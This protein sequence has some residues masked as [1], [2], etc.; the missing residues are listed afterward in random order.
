MKHKT[1]LEKK[2][3][4]M[5]HAVKPFEPHTDHPLVQQIK[6]GSYSRCSAAIA[7]YLNRFSKRA[8]HPADFGYLFNCQNNVLAFG[9]YRRFDGQLYG[10]VIPLSADA[11]IIAGFSQ[12]LLGKL[13]LLG[14]YVRF[15][16]LKSY[17]A[18]LN[19]GFLPAKEHPW[20][21]G[22]VIAG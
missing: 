20:L 18:L 9:V 3:I 1:G 17:V 8:V 14:V 16:G 2:I 19:K 10:C 7:L 15:L 11:D 22:V 12:E 4:S 5:S 6:D 21:R 13:G